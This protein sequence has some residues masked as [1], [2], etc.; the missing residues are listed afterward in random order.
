MQ[1]RKKNI[2]AKLWIA[3]GTCIPFVEVSYMDKDAQEHMGFMMLDTGSTVN[4]LFGDISEWVV[5]SDRKDEAEMPVQDCMG[6]MFLSS[7]VKLSFVFGSSQFT[8]QF[9]CS[10]A[11]TTKLNGD[12]PIIGIL[13]N[14]F[15]E[16]QGLTIDFSNG[17]VYTSHLGSGEVYNL[18]CDFFYPLFVGMENYGVPTVDVHYKKTDVPLIVD[19]GSGANVVSL[20]CI[21]RCHLDCKFTDKPYSLQ[22]VSGINVALLAKVKIALD[23][24]DDVE[25]YPSFETSFMVTDH[26]IRERTGKTRAVEGIIGAPFMVQYGWVIDFGA[27]VI[28]HQKAKV[29]NNVKEK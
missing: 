17:R 9:V 24:M 26:P 6:G 22:S 23:I 8:E 20:K 5:E 3:E 15:L 4:F 2:N 10:G 11:K 13:G 1:K 29:H 7:E 12:M 16:K 21:K 14:N 27:G 28:Y 25:D 19:T 18:G